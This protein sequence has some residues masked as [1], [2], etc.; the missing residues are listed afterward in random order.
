MSAVEA[1]AEKWEE[2]ART[3]RV[4]GV[5]QMLGAYERETLKVVAFRLR[6]AMAAD[7]D[8][9]DRVEKLRTRLIEQGGQCAAFGIAAELA[10]ILYPDGVPDAPV[11]RTPYERMDFERAWDERVK[12]GKI[13]V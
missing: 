8:K 7:A 4:P 1:L 2:R 11:P 3:A 13:N 6:T 12:A 5:D 10:E 9:L